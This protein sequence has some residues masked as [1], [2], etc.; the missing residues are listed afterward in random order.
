MGEE[1]GQMQLEFKRI[2]QEEISSFSTIKNLPVQK[3]HNAIN[4]EQHSHIDPENP[5]NIKKLKKL[6]S[7]TE[8]NP[9]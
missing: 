8:N 7:R 4:N 2:V 5:T 3:I 1:T 6:K 9:L